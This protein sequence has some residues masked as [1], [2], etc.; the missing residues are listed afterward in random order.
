MCRDVFLGSSG[1]DRGIPDYLQKPVSSLVESSIIYMCIYNRL[2]KLVKRLGT[3]VHIGGVEHVS[4][5]QS[6]CLGYPD[7]NGPMDCRS[8]S[9][10]PVIGTESFRTRFSCQG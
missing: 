3:Y 8:G 5:L 7:R 6:G 10:K 2:G 1:R 9:R 4:V